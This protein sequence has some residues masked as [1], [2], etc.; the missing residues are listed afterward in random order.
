V[1]KG[2]KGPDL[3]QEER[4]GAV[5]GSTFWVA[6]SGRT[7]ALVSIL[8]LD[9]RKWNS[10]FIRYTSAG[11]RYESTVAWNYKVLLDAEPLAVPCE[12]MYAAPIADPECPWKFVC[13]D[14]VVRRPG[15]HDYL[16]QIK[17]KAASEYAT[18]WTIHSPRCK[19][20]LKCRCACDIGFQGERL[21]QVFYEMHVARW[22]R[23]DIVV[24]NHVKTQ[25]I[26][27]RQVDCPLWWRS[28]RTGATK[29]YDD[30]LRWYWEDLPRDGE[31]TQ[32]LRAYIAAYNAETL[33]ASVA[34]DALGDRVTVD[35]DALLSRRPKDPTA[36]A[37]CRA[38]TR[39]RERE[40]AR[41][42]R[43]KLIVSGLRATT[44]LPLY[45]PPPLDP[46]LPLSEAL[47]LR[48]AYRCARERLSL[49]HSAKL[50]EAVFVCCV[51]IAKLDEDASTKGALGQQKRKR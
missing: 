46:W 8:Q 3:P 41:V 20:Q 51:S 38:W 34:G 12:L 28:V 19:G 24:G 25:F 23:N 37:K 44:A 49:R 31:S 18:N 2:L 13:P 43:L 7:E 35:I 40:R 4:F 36:I 22:P 32:K 1:I 30:Y 33:K 16:A 21:D 50:M 26:R 29:F 14:I 39:M 27:A 42:M 5:G 9:D 11:T 17:F 45:A 15:Y 47:R 6:A 48:L 10:L